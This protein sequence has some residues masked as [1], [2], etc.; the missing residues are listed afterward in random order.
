VT[1]EAGPVSCFERFSTAEEFAKYVGASG[2]SGPNMAPAAPGNTN[3][4]GKAGGA[5]YLAA[6]AAIGAAVLLTAL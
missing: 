6:T 5:K 1:E 3:A 4:A 2:G